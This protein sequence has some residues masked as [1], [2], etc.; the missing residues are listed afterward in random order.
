LFAT[1]LAEGAGLFWLA[2]VAPAR[3]GWLLVLLFAALVLARWL[4]WRSWRGRVAAV[5]A[6]PALSAIDGPGRQLQW[7]GGAVPIALVLLAVLAA[8][9]IAPVWTTQVLLA[10]AGLCAAVAGTLFKYTLITRSAFNQG[11]RLEQLPVR[12]VPR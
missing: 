5:A 12:G 6:A 9:G 11:F 1:G 7:L 8:S 4:I 2:G 3:G 10:V